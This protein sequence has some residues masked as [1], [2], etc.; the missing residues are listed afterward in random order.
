MQLFTRNHTIEVGQ[1]SMP[2]NNPGNLHKKDSSVFVLIFVALVCTICATGY[3]SYYIQKQHIK[4]THSD[5]LV[6]IADLKVKQIQAW[7]EERIADAEDMF[8]NPIFV[9]YVAQ[10]FKSPGQTLQKKNIQQRLSA[11]KKHRDYANVFLLDADGTVRAAVSEHKIQPGDYMFSLAAEALKKK[12][13][14]LSDL[15]RA[16][17]SAD[18]HM[19]MVIPLVSQIKGISRAIGSIIV[20]IDPGASLFSGIQSWPTPSPSGETL[21]VRREGDFVVYLNALRHKKNTALDLKLPLADA[22]LPAAIAVLGKTGIV[23]GIDY[24]GKFVLSALRQV[25]DTGWFIV[26]KIDAEEVYAPI[27]ERAQYIALIVLTLIIVAGLA[28]GFIRRKEREAHYKTLYG[29]EAA[30]LKEHE[31]AD[32]LLRLNEERYRR[33][34]EAMTDGFAVHEMIC[35]DRGAPIDYRFLEVNRS[36]ERMTGLKREAIVGKT[37]LEIL[38]NIERCWIEQYGKVALSGEPASFENY[39]RELNKYFA[40]EAYSPHKGQFAVVVS[41]ITERKIR[42]DLLQRMTED[43]RRSNKELEQFA[44]IA[45][46][47]LQEPLRMV[48]SYLQLLERRYKG[49]L[50]NNADEFIS[51]AVDGAVRMQRMINDLLSYSRIGTRE[52]VTEPVDSNKVLSDVLASLRLHIEE[53]KAKITFDPLPVVMANASELAQVFQNLINNA[54][55]FHGNNPPEIHLR[56]EQNEHAWLFS[57]QDNGIGLAPEYADKIFALFKRLH[58]ASRYPGSGIGLTICKKIIESRNGRIWVESEPDKGS[59]FYF[60]IPLRPETGG[61]HTIQ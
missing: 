17:S 48:A 31:E 3:Y 30:R 57:V 61:L 24:R 22:D 29:L 15:H 1:Q 10:F 28:A 51:Y 12:K 59:V 60:T 50:D 41:D 47:D 7:R 9:E 42:E 21:L 40:V 54:I 11:L 53:T 27:R 20:Q 52:K 49:K 56:A 14:I 43:L 5:E 46:H 33:L 36:F 19:D 44:Y 26:S 16:P 2:N 4:Q 58:S 13:I 45:S 34:F 35:D 39:S 23:E 37:V 8:N 32:S 25:P 55:K 6:A 38:P 18:I